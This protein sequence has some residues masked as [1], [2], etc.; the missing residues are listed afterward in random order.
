[1]SRDEVDP[2][3]LL[4]MRIPMAEA[5]TMRFGNR[6]KAFR[7]AMVKMKD[8]GGQGKNSR[9]FGYRNVNVL[10]HIFENFGDTSRD[11]IIEKFNEQRLTD[12]V[13]SKEDFFSYWASHIGPLYYRNSIFPISR[14][15]EIFEQLIGKVLSQYIENKSRLLKRL[16]ESSRDSLKQPAWDSVNFSDSK[17]GKRL[18]FGFKNKG[19]QYWHNAKN[20][21]GCYNCGYFTGTQLHHFLDMSESEYHHSIMKQF[22]WIEKKYKG[23]D[24]FDVVHIE[25]DGSFL[26]SWEFPQKTQFECFRRLSKW[27][28]LTHILVE[29][30]PEFIKKDWVAALLKELRRDQV[31]EIAIGVESTDN[32][33]RTH[34]INKGLVGISDTSQKGSIKSILKEI[35]EFGGRVRIQAYL[36]I[37]PAFL[38]E[39]EALADSVN[40]GRVLYQWAKEFSPQRP[41]D[42]LAIK[43]EPVVISRGTILEVLYQS[44]N[45][46]NSE[47]LYTPLNYWTVAELLTQLACDDTY[48]IIRFGAREDMDDYIAIPVVPDKNDTV[49]PID[50]R[51]YDAVQ[52]FCAT[53][54]ISEFLS[55]IEPLLLDHSFSEW[56]EKTNLPTTTLESFVNTYR[57]EISEIKM[58]NSK[59]PALP[60]EIIQKFSTHIQK[61][62]ESINFFKELV[63]QI[64]EKYSESCHRVEKYIGEIGKIYK[65]P[66]NWEIRVNDLRCVY[67]S[68]HKSVIFKIDIKS[69]GIID[70]DFDLW[71]SVPT[72]LHNK[73]LNDK[74]SQEIE[75]KYIIDHIPGKL[76]LNKAPIN[77][78]QGYIAISDNEEVRVRRKIDPKS[79]KAKYVLTRKSKGELSR[80]ETEENIS[81]NIFDKFIMS[82]SGRVI[83]K[84][85]YKIP[86]GSEEEKWMIELDIFKRNLMGLISAEVEF[87]SKE[88]EKEFQKY[89]PDWFG[90]D[91]TFDKR[92]KNNSLATEGLKTVLVPYNRSFANIALLLSNNEEDSIPSEIERQAKEIGLEVRLLRDLVFETVGEI[93]CNV[94]DAV[95]SVPLVIADDRQ[96]S[97]NL[98]T[99]L[100][101]REAA[102]RPIIKLSET[103]TDEITKK[104]DI[105]KQ[106]DTIPTVLSSNLGGYSLSNIVRSQQIVDNE[107][108][109]K[110]ESNAKEIW[111][112]STTLEFDVG[113][114]FN[115]VYGNLLSGKRYHYFIPSLNSN[116]RYSEKLNKNYKKFWELYGYL[117]SNIQ[118]AELDANIISNFKEIVIYDPLMAKVPFG[119]TYIASQ[120]STDFES[121]R[122]KDVYLKRMIDFIKEI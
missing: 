31:M 107:I 81:Q 61:E 11:S 4:A 64:T 66:P 21:L 106:K 59:H 37:K 23:Q 89:K 30:R 104:W 96:V 88:N 102:E 108:L 33:I 78:I 47:H 116:S 41:N 84:D 54:S 27:E 101:M 9:R 25:G 93:N 72:E 50:F 95:R 22:D 94:V 92:F 63:P 35:S 16:S 46:K 36:L 43:Y 70:I 17:K 74:P 119:F 118:F 87:S 7:D 113:E 71:L 32:F 45:E 3:V 56:K 48:K 52:K 111:V 69:D 42:I 114:L 15:V 6:E 110:Y 62:E 73:K 53:R 49:S 117:K 40:S 57:K 80:E 76:L 39:N 86:M 55:D 24:Y 60:H 105:L 34:C 51:L 20:K 90:A 13:R 99:K 5:Y 85:R 1:M 19:C 28:N 2:H 91:V 12:K 10:E 58:K 38:N 122:V 68:L 112:I 67:D 115:V 75:R 120:N 97:L 18:Q 109:S 103:K 121:I 77:I 100:S 82:C 8:I 98:L 29:S 26:N 83:E 44:F 79:Q 65:L 14:Q